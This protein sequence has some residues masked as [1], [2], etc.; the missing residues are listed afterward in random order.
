MTTLGND[1]C[2]RCDACTYCA[3]MAPVLIGLASAEVS[4]ADLR[5]PEDVMKAALSL[6]RETPAPS[7]LQT[8]A[9]AGSRD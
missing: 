7:R 5:V 8:A 6:F 9:P 2:T 3:R 1:G 4:T